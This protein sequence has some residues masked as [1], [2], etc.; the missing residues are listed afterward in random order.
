M[1]Q[2]LDQLRAASA[3]APA[4]ELSRSSISKLPGMILTNGLLSTAAFCDSGGENR[5]D[6]RRAMIATIKHLAARDILSP[7]VCNIRGL[8]EDLGKKDAF[9]LQRATSEALAFLAYLKRFA[10]PR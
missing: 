2:N 3:V 1:H 5:E 8:I 6:L 4:A 10:P 7:D 9:T